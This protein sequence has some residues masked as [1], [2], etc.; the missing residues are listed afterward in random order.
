MYR[1]RASSVHDLYCFKLDERPEEARVWY[2]SKRYNL[3]NSY[4]NDISCLILLG[5]PGKCSGF[6]VIGWTSTT[7]GTYVASEKRAKDAP[8]SLVWKKANADRY[9]FNTGCSKGWR[10][11]DEA[12][13]KDGTYYYKS[14][15]GS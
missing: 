2:L 6:E 9:I 7:S 4:T 3:S 14:K 10:I 12:S 1:T 8:N 13:L 15:K 11:G 5:E